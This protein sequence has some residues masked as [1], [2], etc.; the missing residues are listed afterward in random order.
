[1]YYVIFYYLCG[2]FK[3]I[4]MNIERDLYKELA[5]WK[6]KKNRKPLL[7]QGARQVGKTWLIKNFGE[8]E[9]KHVA[10]FNFEEQIELK[11]F[12]ELTKQANRI[13]DNLSIVYGRTINPKDTL[14]IF[15][16][17]QECN[18]AIN[19]L[20][21][22]NENAPEY[23]I[24]SSGSLLGVS[25]S[26]GKSFPVG[27]VDFLTLYPVSFKEF[28]A[29]ADQNLYKYVSSIKEVSP[30][31][32]IFFN[33]LIEKLRIYF[34]T[35]G[36]PEAIKTILEDNDFNILQ[37]VQ[38]NIIKAYKLDF[39]KHIRSSDIP[40]LD[41]IWSSIPS[42]LA[43]DNKKF[44]Y[45]TIKSGARAREYENALLWLKH[46]GLIHI[47][48]KVNKPGLPLSAYT[49]LSS[50]KVYLLDVGILRQMSNLYPDI[51]KTGN[52]LFSEFKGA[53]TE[54]FILQSLVSQFGTE[55][56]YWTSGNVAEIDFVLQYKNSIIPIEVKAETNIKS[57]SLISYSNRYNPEIKIRYSLKNL[58]FYGDLLN[59]PLFM[60]DFTEGL[61]SRIK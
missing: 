50:F 22:F 3:L 43:K 16:E 32:D 6:S 10:Y 18:E 46:A 17:I 25:L 56:Y 53:F 27:Q 20:K 34:I 12:F 33:Q 54:N 15:D 55:Q 23:S 19:S 51:V 44:L 1:M 7:L 28:L 5:Q 47:V 40:R 49:D 4:A 60:V 39:S 29:K 2:E 24:I 42:Q 38:A 9:Y 36:M 35:G 57:K 61:L 21:Y 11:Q 37:Q 58:S 59:I 45:R 14:I 52:N 31:P 26:S 8:K 41:Y 48:N 30:I 13:I